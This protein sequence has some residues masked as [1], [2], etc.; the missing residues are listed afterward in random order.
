M[1]HQK[2]GQDRGCVLPHG[3]P[4]A[5]SLEERQHPCRSTAHPQHAPLS[6]VLQ[7]TELSLVAYLSCLL[8]VICLHQLFDLACA[9]Q[10]ARAGA[11]NRADKSRCAWTMWLV[12]SCF[13]TT[14]ARLPTTSMDG[15]GHTA[16][17]YLTKKVLKEEGSR[18]GQKTVQSLKIHP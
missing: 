5:A 9:Q 15:W 10:Q 18:A 3:K 11:L 7:D 17:T 14:L 13:C 2:S 1:P 6:W 12:A 4:P 16:L 8:C